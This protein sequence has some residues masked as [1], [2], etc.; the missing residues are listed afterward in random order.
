MI[1]KSYRLDMEVRVAKVKDS[2][3]Q[4][5]ELNEKQTTA[6]AAALAGAVAALE[7]IVAESGGYVTSSSV[8]RAQLASVSLRLPAKAS[9]AA[10]RQI[11]STPN[12]SL[13]SENTNAQVSARHIQS[14]V[15]F[16]LL[17]L[18]IAGRYG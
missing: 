12:C 4:L 18:C 10:L 1:A 7:Q 16:R 15:A 6:N 3:L 13:T 8:S 5:D 11:R 9:A 2:A 17:H 14:A